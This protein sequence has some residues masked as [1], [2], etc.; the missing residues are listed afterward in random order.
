VWLWILLFGRVSPLCEGISCY[1]DCNWILPSLFVAFA[2]RALGSGDG[3]L[4]WLDLAPSG[5]L[6]GCFDDFS[7]SLALTTYLLVT[8][9]RTTLEP[10][11]DLDSKR[12]ARP[13][14]FDRTSP[15]L[16]LDYLLDPSL[17][18]PNI[19]PGD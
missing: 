15:S 2:Q 6:A 13:I 19:P 18:P 10:D 12:M 1:T 9:D 8:L 3:W 11:L 4:A 5:R 16:R 7:G 17:Y 14:G